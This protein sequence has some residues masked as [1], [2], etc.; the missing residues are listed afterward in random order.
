MKTMPNIKT[1][2]SGRWIDVNDLPSYA[3][4]LVR[5]CISVVQNT[6]TRH[7]YT[8]FDLDLVKTTIAASVD[9]LHRHFNLD[10]KF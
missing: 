5:E 8:T 10:K 4:S 2:T 9:H 3:E 7:A 1:D 6:P